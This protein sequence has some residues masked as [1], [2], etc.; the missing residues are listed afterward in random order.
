LSRSA[1]EDTRVC[2]D[3]DHDGRAA[4]R[5]LFTLIAHSSSHGACGSPRAALCQE[6]VAGVTGHVAV[7]ELE[8]WDTWQ[9][10]SCPVSGDGSWGQ[11]ARGG[12]WWGSYCHEAR[13]GSGAA[14]CREMGT[15]GHAGMCAPLAL[16]L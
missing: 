9:P 10:R 12:L 1:L 14:L 4:R 15:T 6:T 7:P 16:R 5:S 11:G 3:G 8:P 2:P 13:G